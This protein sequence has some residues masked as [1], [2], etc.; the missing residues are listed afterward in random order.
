MKVRDLWLLFPLSPSRLGRVEDEINTI[1]R[2]LTPKI[3]I[4]LTNVPTCVDALL[5]IG[6]A[7]KGR[8]QMT[9]KLV[10]GEGE[11]KKFTSTYNALTRTSTTT[12][13]PARQFI[14]MRCSDPTFA[15]ASTG[16]HKIC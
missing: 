5:F 12:Y 15:N 1:S 10:F 4:L 6:K 13:L 9:G 3:P 16:N 2:T 7:V 11:M 14:F 8:T